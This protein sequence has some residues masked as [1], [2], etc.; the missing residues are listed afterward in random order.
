MF[1][2]LEKAVMPMKIG[3]AKDELKKLPAQKTV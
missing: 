3:K 1:G 2:R